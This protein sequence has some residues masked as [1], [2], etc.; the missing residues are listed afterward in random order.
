MYRNKEERKHEV[1]VIIEKLTELKLTS[2][3]DP[4]RK[5]FIELKDYVDNEKTKKINIKFPEIKK[6]IIGELS[7]YK[8][9]ECWLK[10]TKS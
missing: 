9:V 8:N 4:V 5:L 3:Y 2:I 1:K 10:L 6:I 7:I